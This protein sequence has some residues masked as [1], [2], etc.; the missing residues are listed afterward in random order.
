M[1]RGKGVYAI[2]DSR[3]PDASPGQSAKE[4]GW[5]IARTS[6]ALRMNTLLIFGAYPYEEH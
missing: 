4:P 1:L 2:H 6:Q 3:R 5:Q